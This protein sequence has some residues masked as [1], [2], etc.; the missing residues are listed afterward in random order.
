MET[1]TAR[2]LYNLKFVSASHNKVKLINKYT[3]RCI[4]MCLPAD[5]FVESDPQIRVGFYQKSVHNHVR[6]AAKIYVD[7][8]GKSGFTERS[9]WMLHFTSIV[10]IISCY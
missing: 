6:N 2:G 7:T 5:V 9:L 10:T 3:T 4:L 1:C 8:K